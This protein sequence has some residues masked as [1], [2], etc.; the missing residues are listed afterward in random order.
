MLPFLISSC[1]EPQYQDSVEVNMSEMY[2]GNGNQDVGV[3][4]CYTFNDNSADLTLLNPN[5]VEVLHFNDTDLAG[6]GKAKNILFIFTNHSGEPI[7]NNDANST[8]FGMAE[9]GERFFNNDDGARRFFEE[10]SF[11]DF[12]LTGTVVGWMDFEDSTTANLSVNG[13][14]FMALADQYVDLDDY[15]LIALAST[16]PGQLISGSGLEVECVGLDDRRLEYSG[17]TFF[18]R[19]RALTV[20]NNLNT[21]GIGAVMP[22]SIYAHEITHALGVGGHAL[23]LDCH[24]VSYDSACDIIAY[25][26][27]FSIQGDRVFGSHPNAWHKSLL[28]WVDEL[29]TVTETDRFVIHPLEI[30]R[31]DVYGLT[32]PLS[33]PFVLDNGVEYDRVML[34][35]R[36]P[37]DFD[38]RIDNIVDYHYVWGLDPNIDTDG[39]YL[40]FGYANGSDSSVLI[41]TH[42]TD[43]H[44]E[45]KISPHGFPGETGRNAHAMLNVGETFILPN[46]TGTITPLG[47]VG[48]RVPGNLGYPGN[49]VEGMEV[50][51]VIN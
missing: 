16:Y 18:H 21:N 10:G 47:R 30:P 31:G 23:G 43:P 19:P 6:G 2:R 15:D 26:D 34:D 5:D 49:M 12:S 33:T 8:E 1:G 32:I 24:G 29:P 37:V 36:Q 40:Y 11:G 51:V 13:G 38:Y 28:G 14:G 4:D 22:D 35:Y 45:T 17:L 44:D 25:G 39:I 42:P 9:F 48:V 20:S 46:G 50:E 7:V 41:D 3:D 27:P